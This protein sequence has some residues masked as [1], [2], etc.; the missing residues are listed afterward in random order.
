M[1]AAAILIFLLVSSIFASHAFADDGITFRIDKIYEQCSEVNTDHATYSNCLSTAA[2]KISSKM[3]DNIV[4]FSDTCVVRMK[5]ERNGGRC[6]NNG[7][8]VKYTSTDTGSDIEFTFPG[9]K[10]AHYGQCGTC[11]QMEPDSDSE[12][13]LRS[14]TSNLGILLEFP[15]SELAQ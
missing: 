10:S 3:K 8:A 11:S 6:A 4:C 13:P 2:K 14:L 5:C 12:M 7:Y 9:G 15:K 1:K